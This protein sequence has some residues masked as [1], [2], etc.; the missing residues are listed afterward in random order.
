MEATQEFRDGVMEECVNEFCSFDN[1]T[2]ELAM[3]D[4]MVAGYLRSLSPLEKEGLS[5]AMRLLKVGGI[6]DMNRTNGFL[7]YC[8]KQKKG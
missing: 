7:D 4:E 6:F 2:Q 8:L 5:V 3:K 1:E